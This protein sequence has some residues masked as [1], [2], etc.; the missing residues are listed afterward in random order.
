[1][2]F[3][4]DLVCHPC[5][6]GKMVSASHSL[7]TKVMTSKT[8]EFLHIDIVGPARVYSFGGIW[9]MLVVVDGGS[10]LG[11]FGITLAL[12]NLVELVEQVIRCSK[13]SWSWSCKPLK[14]I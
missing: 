14:D 11:T 6:H 10:N 2:K 13:I 5:H 1:L 4:K 3:E 7:V 9:Y 12:G 8:S